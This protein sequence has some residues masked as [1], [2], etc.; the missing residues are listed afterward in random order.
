MEDTIK[1]SK[2][3]CFD[4]VFGRFCLTS[5]AQEIIY[6]KKNI[7][8]SY[9]GSDEWA[10]HF[11]CELIDLYSGCSQYNY[12]LETTIHEKRIPE[13]WKIDKEIIIKWLNNMKDTDWGKATF[14]TFDNIIDSLVER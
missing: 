13:V 5:D 12:A 14:N 2:Y 7:I 10:N 3:L 4:T 1:L 8:C 9:S 11:V 6:H